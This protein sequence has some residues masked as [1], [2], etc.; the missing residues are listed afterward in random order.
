MILLWDRLYIQL[1]TILPL[2][3]AYFIFCLL[4]VCLNY[5]ISEKDSWSE[6]QFLLFKDGVHVCACVIIS[7]VWALFWSTGVLIESSGLSVEV[8]CCLHHS[9][10]C[11]VRSLHTATVLF[12]WKLTFSF[13]KD[14]LLPTMSP[15]HCHLTVLVKSGD[16]LLLTV[17][18]TLMKHKKRVFVCLFP[19]FLYVCVSVWHL[20]FTQDERT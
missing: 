9:C 15:T 16:V 8:Q 18:S 2:F 10:N 5:S 12:N 7:L 1:Y 14:S 3:F 19:A 17:K 20:V 13:L 4:F 6:D 11:H